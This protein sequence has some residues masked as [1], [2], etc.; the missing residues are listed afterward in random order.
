MFPIDGEE[1]IGGTLEMARRVEDCLLES[2]VS[3]MDNPI[4]K[5]VSL[6]FVVIAVLGLKN[7]LHLVPYL[8]ECVIRARAN[9]G[10]EHSVQLSHDRNI[11][12]MA[13]FVPA[14]LIS[15]RFGLLPDVLPQSLPYGGSLLF[16]ASL[17]AA[18]YLLRCS[19]RFVKRPY[20]MPAET[21]KAIANCFRTYFTIAVS[22]MLLSLIVMLILS[23][24]DEVI[25]MVMYVEAAV[26]YLLEIV[27]EWQILALQC[28]TPKT[29]LY[30]CTLE[31][32]PAA[33]W[34]ALLLL[35]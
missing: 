10:I 22:L 2:S 1:I 15:D 33:F 19:F 17:M 8:L 23:A 26:V 34:A 18:Y 35:I 30:L 6:A 20:R 32:L 4:N 31:I 14:C 16:T 7:F 25:R 27:R 11:S 28:S 24:E 3:W 9:V 29:F 21:F 5:W 12:A 13:L